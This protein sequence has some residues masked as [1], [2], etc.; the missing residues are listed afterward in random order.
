MV[1]T[2]L[3]HPSPLHHTLS[4][5]TIHHSPQYVCA[6]PVCVIILHTLY[7][8]LSNMLLLSP[9]PIRVFYT[10]YFHAVLNFHLPTYSLYSPI[11]TNTIHP[12]SLLLSPTIHSPTRPPTPHALSHTFYNQINP[13]SPP[14]PNL[15]GP[16]PSHPQ[17]LFLSPRQTLLLSFTSLPPS[18]SQ[19][20]FHSSTNVMNSKP[21]G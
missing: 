21:R 6:L 18:H 1:P 17:T 20:C 14:L 3:S 19:F 16:S 12:S 2:I 15:P 13:A 10:I 7:P 9:F 5:V 8:F 11:H 4:S